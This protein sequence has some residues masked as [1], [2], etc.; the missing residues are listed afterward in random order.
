MFNK[1]IFMMISLVLI[2]MLV[3]TGCSSSAPSSANS[4]DNNEASAQKH[5]IAMVTDAPI[6]DGG[7]T[8]AC[9]HAMLDAAKKNGYET[10]Y[11]E[12]VKQADYVSMFKQYADLGY[13]LIFAPGAQYSDAIKELAPQYPKVGFILLNGTVEG[14]DNVANVMPN[15]QQIGYL[16][17]ALAGLQTKTNSIGFIGG[18]E[19][20][21]TKTKLASYEAAAKKVNP[22]VSVTNAYAGT[23]DDSAK[24]KEIATSMVSTKN[25]DVIFGDASAVDAGARQ[26]LKTSKD[27]YAIAQPG[28]FL[29]DD[30]ETIISS[31]CTDNSALIDVC[32][33][34]FAAG[35]FGGKTV[36]G[37]LSNGCLSV[38][39]FGQNCP[40]EVQDEFLKIVEQIKDGS[41]IK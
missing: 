30:P 26:G 41:F 40:K 28:D 17:G 16:A 14:I 24:G 36:Y 21:T 37:D 29:K 3:L 6:A 19:L 31:I 23:F 9:Y 20:D 32:M 7:W 22:N 5:K 18:M 34:D 27:R 2:S 8:T 38:G 4:G 33:Q 39:Q 35:K 1:K 10:A 15:A 13:D 11:S 25:V 12:N